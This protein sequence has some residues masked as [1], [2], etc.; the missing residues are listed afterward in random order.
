LLRHSLF[1]VGTGE[2]R[3]QL[4]A[5]LLLLHVDWVGMVA[6][7]GRRVSLYET[8]EEDVDGNFEDAVATRDCIINLL[9]LLNAT[10]E[11]MMA[12]CQHRK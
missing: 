5:A 4:N 8:G 11:S 2:D 3:Y 7:D 10:K 1:A 12:F 9:A 6:T